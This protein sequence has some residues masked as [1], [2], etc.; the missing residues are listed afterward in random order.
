M[1]KLAIDGG[2]PVRSSPI[3]YGRQYIDEDDLKAVRDVLTGDYLTTG[4]AIGQLEATL[5][6]LTGAKYAVAIA[7]GTAALHAACYAANIHSGDEVI[8]TPMTFAAT[9]NSVLYC[10]GTPVFADIDPATYNIDPLAVRKAITPRTKA[11]TAVDFTGQPAQMDALR[12]IC[13]ENDLLLIEDAAHSIGSSFQEM[14]V[15]SIADLTTFSFHPVKTVTGGEGGAILTSDEALYESLSLFRTHGITRNPHQ[16]EWESEGSWYYQQVSLGYNYRMT[17][18]QAALVTSQ[19]NKIDRFAARRR[20][21]VQRY[22]AA[23]SNLSQV[24]LQKEIPEA[25][26]VRHLY[27]LQLDLTKLSVGRRKIVE[28]LTAENVVPNVHYIPVYYHPYY[29]KLGYKKGICPHAEHLYEGIISIPLY[30]SMSDEDVEDV[31]TA[32]KKV[33]NHYKK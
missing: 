19:L 27:I 33:L 10:G 28:A 23:F 11:V 12:K 6:S 20:K 1:E 17:D 9:A 22:D 7:N 25:N 8:T 31:V 4:P 13:Q 18:F 29:K 14:P 5:C 2:V 30:Y 15:G 24:I 16:M 3:H 32:V 26:T 21:I